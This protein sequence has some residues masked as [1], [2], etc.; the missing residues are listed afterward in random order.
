[1]EKRN[2]QALTLYFEEIRNRFV[3]NRSIAWII[4]MV[5]IFM[6]NFTYVA[7]KQP[8]NIPWFVIAII[9]CILTIIISISANSKLLSKNRTFTPK[10]MAVYT[11]CIILPVMIGLE[12]IIISLIAINSLLP[13][14]LFLIIT[15]LICLIFSICLWKRF[16]SQ[17]DHGDY[18]GKLLK[19]KNPGILWIWG[20][21][22]LPIIPLLSLIG[23]KIWFVSLNTTV[24]TLVIMYA[25]LW[26]W[27]VLIY[28][29]LIKAIGLIYLEKGSKQHEY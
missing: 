23:R 13:A 19:L 1:M 3:T 20:A 25:L 15:I 22:A 11:L 28:S 2:Y 4:L 17:V 18:A 14:I 12:I 10:D 27:M 16:L 8:R 24:R 7:A 26:F 6:V 21:T 5:D 9:Y 29:I